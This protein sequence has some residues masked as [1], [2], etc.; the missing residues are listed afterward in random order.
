MLQKIRTL[1]FIPEKRPRLH[2]DPDTTSLTPCFLVVRR[3]F[4]RA[5]PKFFVD[6]QLP[7]RLARWLAAHGH[8][9]LHT[10]DLPQANRT[11]DS[12]I[13]DLAFLEGRV[14][15]SK[16]GDFVDSH[17]VQKRPPKLLLVATGNIPGCQDRSRLPL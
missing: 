13:A 5:A 16:D 6:A 4:K 3:R 9:V 14:V 8:D 10:L 7:K 15:V 17:L 2:Y 11:Q 12:A 1:S